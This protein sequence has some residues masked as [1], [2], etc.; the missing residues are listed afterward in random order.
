MNTAAGAC[1]TDSYITLLIFSNIPSCI[2]SLLSS[3]F[4]LYLS[5]SHT[6]ILLILIPSYSLVAP[7][8][9]PLYLYLFPHL[10]SYLYSSASSPSSSSLSF[11]AYLL[12]FS[13]PFLSFLLFSTLP[14]S[15]F[16]SLSS[17]SSYLIL[18][19]ILSSFPPPLLSFFHLSLSSPSPFLSS[20]LLS[21]PLLFSSLF[22]PL[23][24]SLPL[25]LFSTLPQPHPLS[26]F[27]SAGRLMVPLGAPAMPPIHS[28]ASSI[29]SPSGRDS[30][31][32][33]SFIPPIGTGGQGGGRG[34]S[35]VTYPCVIPRESCL[36]RRR[37]ERRIEVIKSNQIKSNQ[38]KSKFHPYYF[39][40]HY[41]SEGSTTHY[42][43]YCYCEN[44]GITRRPFFSI[45]MT[46]T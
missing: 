4:S 28:S 1:C 18:L 20:P 41:L 42:H 23:T 8:S 5:N 27:S 16:F 15:S 14:L 40:L 39:L 32:Q 10:I 24:L 25:R 7:F 34:Y 6:F 26:S 46:Y 30:Y 21:S 38:I 36:A 2:F 31:Y 33:V 19:L 11:S 43:P 3:Y 13:P 44:H 17:P 37:D 45:R 12:S 29:S 35:G 9:S 22:T